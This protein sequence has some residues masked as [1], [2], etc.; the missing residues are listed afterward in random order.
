M[1]YTNTVEPGNLSLL[2][3]LMQL[4]AFNNFQLVGGTALSL[5]YGHRTSVDLDMFTTSRFSYQQ[6]VNDLEKNFGNRLQFEEKESNFG[7]FSFVDNIKLDFINYRFVQIAETV[8]NSNIRMYSTKDIA[9]MK[10][11]AILGRG[12]K[13]HFWNLA[14]ILNHYTL[15]EITAF[16]EKK[17]PAQRLP[18]SISQAIVYFDEAEHDEDPISLKVKHGHL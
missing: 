16:H 4:E 17:Y 13:K 12:R 3:E 9:A 18:I 15:G 10:I 5:Q 7:L 1:L 6:T 2:N 11:K 14:E 8:I